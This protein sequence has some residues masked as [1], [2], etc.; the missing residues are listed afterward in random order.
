MNQ[1]Q[2]L[3]S[4]LIRDHRFVGKREWGLVAPHDAPCQYR[5][6]PSGQRCATGIPICGAPQHFHAA[7]CNSALN[8]KGEAFRCDWPTDANGK[9]DGWAH[10]NKEAQAVWGEGR[11]Q[12]GFDNYQDAV[13]GRSNAVD[14]PLQTDIRQQLREFLIWIAGNEG[15]VV[16]PARDG[17]YF[18]FSEIADTYATL[19]ESGTG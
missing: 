1:D 15:T 16:M 2:P 5:D 6:V 19:K 8:I 3:S 18:T 11:V 10:T 17:G 9:H 12:T 4:D 13:R 14:I 7:A